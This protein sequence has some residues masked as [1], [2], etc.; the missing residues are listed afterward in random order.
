[1]LVDE[2]FFLLGEPECE[3]VADDE[4]PVSVFTTLDLGDPS[5]ESLEVS[6]ACDEFSLCLCLRSLGRD[7]V[8]ESES[9][10]VLFFLG[11]VVFPSCSE[12]SEDE[13]EPLLEDESDPSFESLDDDVDEEDPGF[14]KDIANEL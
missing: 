5:D 8:P 11:A 3:E 2:G 14:R 12:A 1:M 13:D 4:R 10:F 9:T 6:L 7:P